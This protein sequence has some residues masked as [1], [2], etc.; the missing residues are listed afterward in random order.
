[1]D[2][3]N[4][5]YDM[6][7]Y[8]VNGTRMLNDVTFTTLASPFRFHYT[9][10]FRWFISVLYP[11][12]CLFI[13]VFIFPFNFSLTNLYYYYYMTS[14]RA[15]FL[16]RTPSTLLCCI[17]I[18]TLT[19]RFFFRW[20]YPEVAQCCLYVCFGRVRMCVFFIFFLKPFTHWIRKRK[21]S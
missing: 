12:L 2:V 7:Y 18:L 9:L 3:K 14:E 20:S 17:L 15:R 21:H 16:Q 4:T 1:M 10:L 13:G 8:D 11:M 19:G 6:F 5:K